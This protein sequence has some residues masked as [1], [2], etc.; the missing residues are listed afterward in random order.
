MFNTLKQINERPKPFSI[1]TAR[2]LWTNEHTAQKM[3]QYHLDDDIDASSRNS[4][5]IEKSCK[6]IHEHFNVAGKKVADFGCGPGLY[7]TKL[8][9]RGANVTGIDFSEN[10]IN[11][12]RNIANEKGL[13]IN[14][15]VADYLEF[16]T[17]ETFDLI[18]M[19]MCDYCALSPA[20]RKIMLEKFKVIL[21]PEGSILLDV[22]S[23]NAYDKKEESATYE[24]NQLF[25]F[26]SPNDY[27]AFVN[28]FKYDDEKIALDKYTIIENHMPIREVFNWL[29]HF[30][31]EMIH[32]ELES[33]GLTIKEYYANVAGDEFYPGADE[34]AVQA[35]HKK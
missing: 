20:Q 24:K 10:S 21:K 7:A 35:N 17:D 32:D 9:E 29:Q 26:W 33:A 3:L 16:K 11:Y 8:A 12:A 28:S 18:I 15:H 13:D 22:Y 31:P 30:N 19:I 1:Y 2:E 27:Y 4:T 25:G 23:L 14:Y 5:F 6:W 34:Y